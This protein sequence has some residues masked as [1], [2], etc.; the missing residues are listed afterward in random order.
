MPRLLLTS[1]LALA[2]LLV[3]CESEPEA[4]DGGTFEEML[5]WVPQGMGHTL[6]LGDMAAWN[7][8]AGVETPG[9]PEGEE[10]YLNALF[11]HSDEVGVGALQGP[12]IGAPGFFLGML[13]N[14]A[15]LSVRTSEA[16][17]FG[18][19]D[20]GA[21]AHRGDVSP[22]Q[23]WGMAAGDFERE[24]IL[25]TL[26]E[27]HEC[28][29]AIEE[30][31]AGETVYWWGEDRGGTRFSGRN[32]NALPLFDDLGRG[33]TMAFFDEHIIRTTGVDLMEQTLTGPILAEDEQWLRTARLFDDAGT[34]NAQFITA[35]D[36]TGSMAGF[37]EELGIRQTYTIPEDLPALDPYQ[38]LAAGVGYEDESPITLLVLGFEDAPTAEA[39]VDIVRAR[40]EAVP[41]AA[42]EGTRPE[43]A[44]VFAWPD[45]EIVD[46]RAEGDL[47]V[48]R[49]G[50]AA[51]GGEY[52]FALHT[53]LP[54]L[55]AAP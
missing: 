36:H 47:V 7:E 32:R 18:L 27:C 6:H 44:E 46:V 48:V 15:M 19:R 40:L 49:L 52:L 8:F 14:D 37:V 10:E 35:P 5:A 54:G 26:D 41:S 25:E 13:P 53:I 3:A 2:A 22:P 33:G 51:L 34:L 30:T 12:W 17:G 9:G 20:I 11:Q 23:Q 31:V 29:P 28:E 1:I 21:V 38:F 4:S 16:F 55:P 43:R 24:A 42:A 45:P 50:G 39:N